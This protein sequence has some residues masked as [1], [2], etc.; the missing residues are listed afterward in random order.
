MA[1]ITAPARR[2]PGTR[3][4]HAFFFALIV[5]LTTA[6]AVGFAHTYFLAGVFSAHLPNLLIHIHG[7]VFTAWF[8]LLIIQSALASSGRV[9]LHRKLGI[10]GMAIAA[11][12][13]PLG[14]L[15]TAEFVHRQSAFRRTRMASIMPC[16]E[17]FTFAVLAT[18]AFLARRR[19]DWH[20]RLI[21]LA[22]IG[23]IGA[24]V[25]RMDFL[26]YW[27]FHGPA[28][29][30]LAW[31]YTYP[32]LILLAAYDLWSIRRLHKATLWGSAFIIVTHQLS[33]LICTT[34]TWDAFAAWMQSWNL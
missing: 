10:A 31:A 3:Y 24:A 28:S 9:H 19:S 18:A 30:R 14:V 2:L 16:A 11:L 1:T 34:A 8:V 4:D 15:A 17:L 7:A 33:L 26:P 32:F 27:H 6:M 12:M 23:I 13:V 22:T 5:L 25:G 21:I 20:K 29:L